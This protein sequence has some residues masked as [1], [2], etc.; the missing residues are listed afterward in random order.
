MKRIESSIDVRLRGESIVIQGTLSSINYGEKKR[1][2]GRETV[3]WRCPCG[4]DIDTATMPEETLH[5]VTGGYVLE[6][7]SCGRWYM[8][9][10]GL[11]YVEG[12]KR[13]IEGIPAEQAAPDVTMNVKPRLGDDGR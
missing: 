10:C 9:H 5:D 3:R 2:V 11:G 8:H 4:A 6:C 13:N 7:S 12:G 1:P